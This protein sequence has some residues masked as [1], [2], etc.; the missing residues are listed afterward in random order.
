MNILILEPYFTGSHAAWAEGYAKHSRLQVEIL[1]LSGNF[2]KWRIHGGAVTLAR[3]FLA[4][5]LKPDL[6]LATDMLDLTTFLALTRKRTAAVP[7]AAYFHENQLCYPWSASDR[8]VKYERDK[9]YGFI[10]YA[11]ALAADAVF[12]NSDYHMNSFLAELPRF[13]KDFPDHQELES[14]EAIK[15]KSC[16]LPLGLDLARFD[17]FRPE[18]PKADSQIQNPP[19]G[20]ALIL[21]NHRWE[22]DKNPQEFFQAL[23]ALAEKGVDFEVAV[24]GECFSQKPEEFD[25]A[26]KKLG[27]RVVQFG[28]VDAFE[29][30]ARWLWRADI[31][32]VTSIQDFFGTSVVEAMYCQCFPLLPRRLA[33]PELIPEELHLRHFYEGFDDLVKRLVQA[34]KEVESFRSHTLK[35]VA[36]AYDWRKWAPIYDGLWQKFFAK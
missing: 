25:Q 9:H 1:S 12:F 28:Y 29:E 23:F 8:D 14:A 11:T 13:L 35:S 7:T 32:P 17:P 30:Y 19:S 4:S 27:K 18:T 3:Q 22:Y 24:L 33:Y 31:L 10:N 5:D 34:V 2:W 16:V 20:P 36:E 21:W 15:S 26:R 6:L